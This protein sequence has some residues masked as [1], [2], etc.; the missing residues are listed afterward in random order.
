MRNMLA[1]FAAMLVTVAGAGWYLGWYT[2]RSTPA[3]DG[4]SSVTVDINTVKIARDLRAAEERVQQELAERSKKR[5]SEAAK[6]KPRRRSPALIPG[7]PGPMPRPPR[8]RSGSGGA[9]ASCSRPPSAR[10]RADRALAFASARPAL[11]SSS[12]PGAPRPSPP[13]TRGR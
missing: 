12:S 10:S 4:Q 8:E 5:Q 13:R 2:V 6:E 11:T 1:F 3:P 9:P 7:S